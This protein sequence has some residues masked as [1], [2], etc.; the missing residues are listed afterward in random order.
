MPPAVTI[1]SR[2]NRS[3][4]TLFW[5]SMSPGRWMTFSFK[6]ATIKTG[7]TWRLRQRDIW[8][9]TPSWT[10]LRQR[11]DC[12]LSVTKY[13]VAKSISTKPILSSIP[14]MAQRGISTTAQSVGR[15]FQIRTTQTIKILQSGFPLT[16]R[17]GHRQKFMGMATG[18][19]M[20]SFMSDVVKPAGTCC[21]RHWEAFL[22][23]CM[24]RPILMV[25]NR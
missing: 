15:G 9:R 19:V 18:H 13:L 6:G 22:K 8:L 23:P 1:R 21:R 25:R 4:W 10:N 11:A 14:P 24:K 12:F 20:F 3:L 16:T 5:Y 2:R 17:T 7:P